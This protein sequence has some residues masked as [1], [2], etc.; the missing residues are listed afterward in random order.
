MNIR[1]RVIFILLTA[2]L[3]FSAVGCHKKTPP[4]APSEEVTGI[5]DTTIVLAENGRSDYSIVIG[6][7]ASPSEIFSA[8]ELQQYI[9]LSTGATLPIINDPAG[10]TESEHIL[11]VGRTAMLAASEVKVDFDEVGR[12]GFK[13]VRKD[14]TVYI[15]GG[16]DTGTSFGVFE[17]LHDEVGYEPY[18]A[19]EIYYDKIEKL[20]VKDFNK[21][22]KPAIPE[23]FMDGTMHTKDIDS[24]Y[25]YRFVNE[26]VSKAQYTDLGLKTWI[27]SS[28]HAFR[29]MLPPE[30]WKTKLDDKW[31][32]RV[33][34]EFDEAYGEDWEEND[35]KLLDEYEAEWKDKSDAQYAR[36]Y[37]ADAQMCLTDPDMIE[38]FIAAEIEA[39]QENP[40]GTI[41]GLGQDD[42][43]TQWCQCDACKAEYALYGNGYYMRWCNKVVEGV[44]AW[45][46]ENDP[47]RKVMYAPFAYAMSFIPPVDVDATTG[48][49]KVKD[50]SCRPHEK[51]YIRICTGDFCHTH[52]FDDPTCEKNARLYEYVKRWTW[53][54]DRVMVWGYSANYSNYL[55][56][57]ENFGTMQR[58]IQMFRDW[59]CVNLFMEYNSGA[60]LMSFDYLRCYLFG[61]LCWNPD[62]D[63]RALTDAFF[64]NYYKELAPEMREIFD[65]YRS[66]MAKQDAMGVHSDHLYQK[67]DAWSRT[68]VDTMY[69]KI[70]AALDKC[71][72]LGLGETLYNRILGERVC[73]RYCR[74][75]GYE[76][77]GYN[78]SDL[79]AEIDRFEADVNN[80]GVRSNAEG[81]T[82]DT[83]IAEMRKKVYA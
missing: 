53:L 75:Y 26:F 8:E 62:V 42:F 25:R 66:N 15:C 46:K 48:E 11:S 73:I 51:I 4:P 50:E 39:L 47:T 29:G 40:D 56:F 37:P 61:K 9:K 76:T 79:G 77:Y 5:P 28:G 18:A 17:F 16:K 70:Q 36:W 43:Y 27:G 33:Q 2:V 58:Q 72:R 24:G 69:D 21:T 38:A 81:M 78:L 41:M 34:K 31:K 30:E 44:E 82:I 83:F 80:L 74:L 1:K 19:D 7:A 63:V 68:F 60:N 49:Y 22:D 54:T 71:E 10:A 52:D 55:P 32:E 23:R 59:G 64:A 67:F 35:P 3:C 20:Y 12:D 14:N 13:I 57:F 45:L 65:L 6:A